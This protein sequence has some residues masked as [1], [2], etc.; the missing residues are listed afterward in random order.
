MNPI[1]QA[2]LS[3]I[4]QLSNISMRNERPSIERIKI[5]I[6]NIDEQTSPALLETLYKETI[7]LLPHFEEKELTAIFNLLTYGSELPHPQITLA[8]ALGDFYSSHLH[9][10]FSNK[11]DWLT[12]FKFAI[13]YYIKAAHIAEKYQYSDL[14][15][16]AHQKASQLFIYVIDGYHLGADQK[17]RQALHQAGINKNEEDFTRVCYQPEVYRQ[18]CTCREDFE[19]LIRDKL[20]L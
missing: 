14:L 12:G 18:F 15:D 8:F 16:K 20:Y 1:S 10:A 4:S 2:T 13:R 19:T 7:E 3:S 17:F 11:I 5:Q 9:A 6:A